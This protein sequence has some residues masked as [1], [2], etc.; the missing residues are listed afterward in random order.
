MLITRQA[1]GCG[2]THNDV[3]GSDRLGEDNKA[4]LGPPSDEDLRGILVET[5]GDLVNLLGI[6]V[7]R[8]SGVIVAKRRVCLNEDAVVLAELVQVFLD[9][10]GVSLDLIDGGDDTSRID[11][12]LELRDCEVGHADCASLLGLLVDADDLFPGLGDG[13]RIKVNIELAVGSLGID[14]LARFKGDRPVD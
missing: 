3:F 9:V 1:S 5:L 11:N 7:A 4:V 13:G 8:L 12:V 10:G 14:L 6:D 2:V